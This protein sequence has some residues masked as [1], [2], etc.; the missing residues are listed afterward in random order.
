MQLTLPASRYRVGFFLPK[1]RWSIEPATFLSWTKVEDA[2]GVF[3]YDLEVGALYHEAF[4]LGLLAG[5]SFF[6]R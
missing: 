3:V 1:S 5:L 6:T 4:R 2:D